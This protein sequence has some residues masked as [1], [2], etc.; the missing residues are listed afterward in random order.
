VQ[1]IEKLRD[2]DDVSPEA[3][4]IVIAAYEGAFR[5][6]WI[7]LTAISGLGLLV[8]LPTR[9]KSLEKDEVGRQGLKANPTAE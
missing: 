6:I 9:E 2:L 7:V 8:S 5:T 1:F 4:R 3:M